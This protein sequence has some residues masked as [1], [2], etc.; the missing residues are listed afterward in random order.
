MNP[1]KKCKIG[2]EYHMFNEEWANKYFFDNTENKAVYLLSHK[3][4]T[5]FKDY[6]LK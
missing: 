6:N 2:D 1:L 3:M 4:I 5:I